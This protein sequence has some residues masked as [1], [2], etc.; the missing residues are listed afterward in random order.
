MAKYSTYELKI[1]PRY[2]KNV[3]RVLRTDGNN[4]LDGLCYEILSAFD[5]DNDHLYMFSLQRKKYD[6]EG[7]YHPE[8]TGGKN[9]EKISLNELNLKVR[10]KFLFLYDFGDE[11]MFDITVKKIEQS[12]ILTLTYIKEQKGEISQYPDWE[13]EDWEEDW[14]DENEDFLEE[15]HNKDEIV[16]IDSSYSMTELLSENKPSELKTIMKVLGMK[17]PKASKRASEVYAAEIVRFLSSNKQKLLDILTPGAAYLLYCI[18]NSDVDE[19]LTN[20]MEILSMDI[21]IDLGLVNFLDEYDSHAIEVTKDLYKFGDFFKD[22]E[23][24]NRIKRNY[25]WQKIFISLINIYG[26]AELEFFYETLCKYLKTEI[27]FKEFEKNVVMPMALWNEVNVYE[28]DFNSIATLFSNEITEHILIDRNNFDVLDYKRYGNEEL[29]AAIAEGVSSIVPNFDVLV[30]YLVV[31]KKINTGT[32][33]IF[34]TEFSVRC[35]MGEDSDLVIEWCNEWLDDNSLKLTKK[36][37]DILLK[38]IQQHPCAVLM[39]YSRDEYNNRNNLKDN[40]ISLFDDL[41]F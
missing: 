2:W 4:T 31:D 1:E 39:G 37:K 18:V 27:E 8:A 13:D 11:W 5:F 38:I 32:L 22:S 23:R 21:L 40:Q 26:V 29:F 14:E 9:A 41:P 7:Y 12:D 15:S 19:I 20:N 17:V 3:Y 16:L 10:N 6:S 35:L 36:L 24:F 33:G 28:T 34:L 30:E 25:E